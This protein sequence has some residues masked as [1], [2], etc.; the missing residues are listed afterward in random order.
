MQAWLLGSLLAGMKNSAS[1]RDFSPVSAVFSHFDPSGCV[2]A[3]EDSPVFHAY[4]DAPEDPADD[5]Y[6]L[7][8]A[9]LAAS[10]IIHRFW[11]AGHPFDRAGFSGLGFIEG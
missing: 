9:D 5:P 3:D 11:H 1:L 6:V 2:V 8:F 7:A 10:D 4:D